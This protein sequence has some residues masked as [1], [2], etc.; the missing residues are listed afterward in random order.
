MNLADTNSE[1]IP[2]SPPSFIPLPQERM[3]AI[4]K[5]KRSDQP[6]NTKKNKLTVNSSSPLAWAYFVLADKKL[7]QK[8]KNLY[9]FITA[10]VDLQSNFV[11]KTIEINLV[12]ILGFCQLSEFMTTNE[13]KTSFQ[14]LVT[15]GFIA[16]KKDGNDTKYFL[17]SLKKVYET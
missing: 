14:E 12:D 2:D 6:K 5:R 8:A 16:S 7:S 10:N 13:F 4:N 1:N 3:A 9:A 15:R 11:D 17:V